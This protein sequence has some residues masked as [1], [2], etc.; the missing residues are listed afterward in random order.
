M[1]YDVCRRLPSCCNGGVRSGGRG[2][3]CGGCLALRGG[4]LC[5]QLIHFRLHV[6]IEQRK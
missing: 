5:L 6:H 2:S 3:L 1:L 4:E